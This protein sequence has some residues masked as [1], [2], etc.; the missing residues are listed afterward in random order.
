MVDTNLSKPAVHLSN[1]QNLDPASQ[2][3]QSLSITKANRFWEMIAVYCETRVGCVNA[4]CGQTV[5]FF[6]V[7]AYGAYSCHCALKD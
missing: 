7:K 4:L 1:I 2:K 6:Y 5:Y 3:T